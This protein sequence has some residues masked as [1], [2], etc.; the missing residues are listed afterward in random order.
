MGFSS[1]STSFEMFCFLCCSWKCFKAICILWVLVHRHFS[2]PLT[3]DLCH[4]H[5]LKLPCFHVSNPYSCFFIMYF[6]RIPDVIRLHWEFRKCICLIIVIFV[7]CNSYT[8]E[9]KGSFSNRK[10]FRDGER[11]KYLIGKLISLQS[12]FHL[13]LMRVPSVSVLILFTC[14]VGSCVICQSV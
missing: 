2:L 14:W 5:T 6:L 10:L 8:V 3:M 1:F 13:E 11:M 9:T 4:N 7:M 12:E